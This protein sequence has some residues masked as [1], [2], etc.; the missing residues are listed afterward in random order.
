M[1]SDATARQ[2]WFKAMGWK[3]NA[4]D[5]SKKENQAPSSFKVAYWH[6]PPS[7]REFVGGRWKLIEPKSKYLDTDD[8]EWS[9]LV[10][11][12]SPA[13]FIEN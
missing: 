10:P 3:I 2:E 9:C 5:T 11:I 6:F 8:K 4:D 7:R 12:N 1:P 13:N